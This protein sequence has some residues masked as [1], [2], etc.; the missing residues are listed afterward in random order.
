[1]PKACQ[2]LREYLELGLP[3]W[4]VIDEVKSGIKLDKIEPL[5]NRI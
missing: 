3:S 1:M 5:F 4:N 2:K